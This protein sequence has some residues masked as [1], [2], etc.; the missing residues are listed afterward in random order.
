MGVDEQN[1]RRV[2]LPGLMRASRECEDLRINEITVHDG[3]PYGLLHCEWRI[4]C[5]WVLCRGR[6]LCDLPNLVE[7]V[8]E[9]RPFP[10]RRRE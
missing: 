1:F 4:E 5:C 7:Y 2:N 6:R 8:F 10:H 3:I 9:V